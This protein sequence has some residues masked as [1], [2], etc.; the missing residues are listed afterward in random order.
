MQIEINTTSVA[1]SATGFAVD[2]ADGDISP[3]QAISLPAQSI[4]LELGAQVT[5]LGDSFQLYGDFDFVLSTSGFQLGIQAGMSIL[6][7][8][9]EVHTSFAVPNWMTSLQVNDDLGLKSSSSYSAAGL[10]FKTTG[11][12]VLEINAADHSAIV[13]LVNGGIQ[14][15]FLSLSVNAEV[16]D[17]NGTFTF[18][19]GGTAG[20]SFTGDY[21]TGQ[22][23]VKIG[24]G[25]FYVS[26]SGGVYLFGTDNNGVFSGGDELIGGGAS[27]GIVSDGG[28][29]EV[30]LSVYTVI[31]GSQTTWFYLDYDLS[32]PPEFAAGD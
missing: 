20:D 4:V 29:K 31:D 14:I 6:S 11:E 21:I 9:Y 2:P 25:T 26:A 15:N 27:G 7:T 16:A 30:E 23:G 19:V 5:L 22:F 12:L 8:T 18:S 17:L 32:S 3:N 24:N 28:S 13:A 10:D 1:E